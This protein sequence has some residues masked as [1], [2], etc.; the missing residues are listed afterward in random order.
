MLGIEDEPIVDYDGGDLADQE[1]HMLSAVLNTVGGK[2]YVTRRPPRLQ[3]GKKY[4]A[5]Q[6]ESVCMR[7]AR[8]AIEKAFKDVELNQ[9]VRWS[10]GLP[11]LALEVEIPSAGLGLL[12]RSNHSTIS[13]A[14]RIAL[15]A[16]RKDRAISISA[17]GLAPFRRSQR[18]SA[19]HATSAP[20]RWRSRTISTSER[21]AE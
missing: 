13:R 1:E 2:I 6:D 3:R 5:L 14:W 17:A 15:S 11:R 21:L 10:S 20:S 12:G 9:F 18:R 16:S 19:S 7:R 8:Q 4:S